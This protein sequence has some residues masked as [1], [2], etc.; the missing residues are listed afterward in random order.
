LSD[1]LAEPLV[2]FFFAFFFAIPALPDLDRAILAGSGGIV[3]APH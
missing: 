2:A 3:M 1:F